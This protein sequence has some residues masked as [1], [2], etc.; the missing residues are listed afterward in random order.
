MQAEDNDSDDVP[1]RKSVRSTLPLGSTV[2]ASHNDTRN[3]RDSRR[4]RP[5]LI[6][7]V[8]IK[9]DIVPPVAGEGQGTQNLFE[10]APSDREISNDVLPIPLIV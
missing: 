5:F 6:A 3:A 7:P 9:T 2:V 10:L 4:D 1:V 8:A